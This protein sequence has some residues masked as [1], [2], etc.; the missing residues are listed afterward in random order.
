MLQSSLYDYLIFYWF[1]LEG[2]GNPPPP[3]KKKK[4]TNLPRTYE[5][6]LCK[7]QL[8]YIGSAVREILRY[9]HTDKHTERHPV[10]L[11]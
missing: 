3:K 4:V 8:N 10:T 2:G 1:L 6:F 9:K 5:K 7:G 11:I